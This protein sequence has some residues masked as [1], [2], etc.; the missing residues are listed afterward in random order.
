MKKILISQAAIL[1]FTYSLAFAG[2]P[3]D[4]I[5][6]AA[7][8]DLCENS[9]K[10]PSDKKIEVNSSY[11]FINKK[12][13]VIQYK[14]RA[15][16]GRLID[17]WNAPET[18]RIVIAH[19]GDSHVQ[20]GYLVA[21]AR[22]KLQELKGK[23]GRGMIFPYAIAKTYSQNDYSTTFTG[24]WTTANSMQYS[25]KIPLGISGFSAK[26]SDPS[27]SFTF[28][29][30]KP[31]DPGQKKIRVFITPSS[32]AYHIDVSSGENKDS[33]DL[34]TLQD[35]FGSYVD[36]T[37]PS[38]NENLTVDFA[39]TSD[40]PADITIHGVSIENMQPGVIYHDLGVG[41][42]AYNAINAQSLFSQELPLIEPDLII[43]DYGTNDIL[44]KN[45]IPENH[46]DTVISTIKK[47]RAAYPDIA[48][49]L[50]S[51]QDMN[52]KGKNISVAKAF[53]RLMKQIALDNHCLF[54]D[55]YQVSGDKNTMKLWQAEMLSQT[56]NVH[57]NIKGY[58]LKGSLLG[59]ALISSFQKDN[60]A[61][62]DTFIIEE[63]TAATFS[64]DE[65]KVAKLK[66]KAKRMNFKGKKN[67]YKKTVKTSSANKKKSSK[68]IRLVKK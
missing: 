45:E 16:F 22:E 36:L 27:A 23:G 8:N 1:L 49:L 60:Q 58:Q 7:P 55:W 17:K 43:V 19:F 2:L 65:K 13:N 46:T 35:N 56:D 44:F 39:N 53:A 40:Q 52:Y 4:K 12:T 25:P 20:N 62:G 37:L 34:T 26:T 48:I 28:N 57:L 31:L 6:S 38:I 11:P 15:D 51:T 14:T 47:I 29:F 50:T 21:T 33:I 24:A 3:C 59:D 5:Q 9:T 63:S 68:P 18:E 41:G 54:Y 66:G 30:S 67:T 42:A 61:N 64:G 32:F 10:Q